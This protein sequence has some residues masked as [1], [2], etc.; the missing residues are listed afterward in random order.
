[1][2]IDIDPAY[3]A[4]PFDFSYG[5]CSDTTTFPKLAQLG[6][7]I[8]VRYGNRGLGSVEA[9]CTDG[10]HDLITR[11]RDSHVMDEWIVPR[12]KVSVKL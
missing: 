7:E 5:K 4:N 8:P 2:G 3:R 12:R 10:N 9:V 6:N 11:V 1:M